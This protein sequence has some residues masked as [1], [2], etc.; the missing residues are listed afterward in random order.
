MNWIDTSVDDFFRGMGL[1]N[2]DFSLVG[3][4]QL[5]FEKSGTLHIERHDSRLYLILSR[6]LPWDRFSHYAQSALSLCHVDNGW[7]FLIK[8]GLLDE[9]TLVFSAEIEAQEVTLPTI[10]QAF[11]LLNR[12]HDRVAEL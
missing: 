3:R 10:E 4:A 11:T 5:N 7:P 1:D 12:L 6:E 9:Q 8:T 2:I